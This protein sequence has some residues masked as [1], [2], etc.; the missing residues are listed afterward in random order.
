MEVGNSG[1]DENSGN[2]T[3]P[4]AAGND[5]NSGNDEILAAIVGLFTTPGTPAELSTAA[6]AKLVFRKVPEVTAAVLANSDTFTVTVTTKGERLVKLREHET[7]EAPGVDDLQAA[8][9]VGEVEPGA[10]PLD[11]LASG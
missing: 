2:P 10:E 6:L 1:N 8:V 5:G 9:P 7:L 3:V 11:N 4:E